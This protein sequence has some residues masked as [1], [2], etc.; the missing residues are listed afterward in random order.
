MTKV[1]IPNL[2][3]FYD[4]TT[5]R[6]AARI[7]LKPAEAF[8]E[9]VV[10]SVEHGDTGAVRNRIRREYQHGDFV[11]AVGDVVLLAMAI[12]EAVNVC[13]EVKVLRWNKVHQT[14][15]EEVVLK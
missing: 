10:L 3:I 9:L 14:Y 6:P 4:Q 5:G 15:T 7:D 11:V 2:P 12:M 8:G 1:F 13:G